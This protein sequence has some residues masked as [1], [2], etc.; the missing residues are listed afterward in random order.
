MDVQVKDVFT[1]TIGS[2]IAVTWMY[3]FRVC[4]HRRSAQLLR[5]RGCTGLG[6]VYRDDQLNYCGY[7][8]VQ[9]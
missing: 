1:E 9:I 5:L 2:T 8:D 3:R 4:L 7:V 6:S